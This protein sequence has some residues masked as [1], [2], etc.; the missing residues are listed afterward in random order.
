M[1]LTSFIYVNKHTTLALG[2]RIKTL[3]NAAL[4]LLELF[5]I[6]T[7]VTSKCY[8]ME[9][10]YLLVKQNFGPSAHVITLRAFCIILLVTKRLFS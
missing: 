8:Q 5:R 9:L 4:G 6:N 1:R 2:M 10:S 7:T 3:D